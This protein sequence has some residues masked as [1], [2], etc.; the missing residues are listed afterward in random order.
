M[1]I[2]NGIIMIVLVNLC[3][4]S[5]GEE[6]SSDSDYSIDII[7]PS[8]H[9]E[10]TKASIDITSNQTG[11]HETYTIVEKPRSSP[12][13]NDHIYIDA[14]YGVPFIKDVDISISDTDTPN[15]HLDHI[16]W[17]II[18]PNFNGE[19]NHQAAGTK[20]HLTS[21]VILDIPRQDINWD[22]DVQIDLDGEVIRNQ[23]T[24]SNGD[25]TL[26]HSG[27]IQPNGELSKGEYIYE[28]KAIWNMMQ[29][30]QITEANTPLCIR[31]AIMAVFIMAIGLVGIVQMSKS[32]KIKRLSNGKLIEPFI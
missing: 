9:L 16:K 24:F 7:I 25:I 14:S 23:A 2:K 21:E 10:D 12:E 11:K 1:G 15:Y 32:M 8:N 20:E 19:F 29:T 18:N 13:G 27:E 30:S 3:R 26:E 22:L 5:M 6:V 28:G 17:T 4:L 31:K